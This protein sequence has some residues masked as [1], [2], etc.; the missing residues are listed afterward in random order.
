M[1][2]HTQISTELSKALQVVR[3]ALAASEI[4]VKVLTILTE[5][6]QGTDGWALH[7]ENAIEN[8]TS[9]RSSW[10]QS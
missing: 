1:Q 8:V 2:I 6:L 3:S 7:D 9:R 10:K 4:G 5:S